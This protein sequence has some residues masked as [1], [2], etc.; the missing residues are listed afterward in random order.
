MSALRLR[1]MGAGLVPSGS[2]PLPKGRASVESHVRRRALLVLAITAS[3]SLSLPEGKH[4]HILG[5][6][7]CTCNGAEKHM[8]RNSQLRSIPSTTKHPAALGTSAAPDENV[9]V[10]AGGVNTAGSGSELPDR[11]VVEQLSVP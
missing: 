4:G 2:W 10:A 5:A 3:T 11:L 7:T 1:R 9:E 8:R 6:A